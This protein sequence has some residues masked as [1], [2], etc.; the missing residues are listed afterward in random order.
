MRISGLYTGI[1]GFELGF[2]RAGHRAILLCEIDVHASKVLR[3]RLRDVQLHADVTK[4]TRL[5]S[6][7]EVVT[8]GFPCQNLSMAGDKAGI[9]GGKSAV[10]DRLFELLDQHPVPWVV[11]ENVYFMLHLARGAA[12]ESILHRL[13]ERS[14]RWAYRVIDSRAFGLPQRRRRVFIVASQLHDPRNVPAGRRCAGTGMASPRHDPPD[15]IL[16]DGRQVR[17]WPHRG[18]DSSLEGRFRVGNP[19]AAGRPAAEHRTCRDPDDRGRGASPRIPERLDLGAP[20]Q[21]GA[22]VSLAAGRKC[23]VCSGDRVDWTAFVGTRPLRRFGRRSARTRRPLAL[24]RLGFGRWQNVVEGLRV[25]TATTA[26]SYLRI[27]HGKLARLVDAGAERIRH[28]CTG[29]HP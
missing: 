1:G 3:H 18:C 11:I 24:C 10:I 26:W 14:Y 8:A 7:T 27:R 15:R 6:A 22:T 21:E 17:K 9:E 2:E 25:A 4:L 12:I 29:K 20:R 23:C 19:F 16:L 5:P 13:S 28:A